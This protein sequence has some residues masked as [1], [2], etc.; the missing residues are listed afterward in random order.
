MN[1]NLTKLTIKNLEFYAFHGVKDEE[2]KL[3]GRYQM[4]LELYYDSSSAIE[5]DKLSNALNFEDILHKIA[6][7]LINKN[8]NLIETLG[9]QILQVVADNYP[10][11]KK[12]TVRIRKFNIPFK[13]ILDY[14][15]T[16]QYF[17]RE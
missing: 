9:N 14:I 6:Y 7:E 1:N 15:E 8:F 3:G 16:E 2:K 13:G 10:I 5:S 4:D 12:A 17:E 11:L